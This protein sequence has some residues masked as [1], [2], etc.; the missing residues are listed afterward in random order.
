[1]QVPSSREPNQARQSPVAAVTGALEVA[2]RGQD[3]HRGRGHGKR[4]GDGDTP[5]TR[6]RG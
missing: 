4:T 1:M 6:I 3:G 2:Q 5:R